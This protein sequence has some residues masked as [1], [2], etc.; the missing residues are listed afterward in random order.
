[1]TESVA[2]EI[3]VRI[4]YE[5]RAAK[6]LLNNQKLAEI[7]AY[8]NQCAEEGSNENQVEESKKAMSQMNAII[9]D[10]TRL[11]TVAEDF[12][13]HYE[14]RIAEG[15]T[16]K[17]KAM[18]VCS[19]RPIAYELYKNIL[20][21][22]P[23]WGKVK[24]AA[25]DVFLSDK[26]KKEIKPMERIKM[27]MTR[28]K[29]DPE[30]LYHLL[31]TKDDRKELDR[32]FKNEK[33][34]FKIAIVV[35]M[36]LTGFDVPFLDTMYIDK[37]IQRHNLIQ[38][39]SRVNRKFEGKQK[40]L[41]VDYIGIKKQMNMAL[42]LYS[43]ADNENIEDIEQSVVVVKDQLDLLSRL[44]Y[45]FDKSGYFTGTPLEQLKTL[46]QASE[47]IQLTQELEK[48]FMYIVKRLKSA[49]DICSGSGIFSEE[50][51]D[52]IHFYLAVRSIIFKLTKGVA[53]DTAE[54]N[55]RVKQMLQDAIESDGIEEIFK[56]GDEG[57][58]EVDIFSDDYM[59]K[60]DKIKLPNTKI[61]LLQKLLAKAIDDVKRINKITG[62]DFSKR[63]QFIV[64]KYNERK[65]DDVL[66]S[67]VLEDFTD[68]II[69]LYYA[70]KKEKES[71]K[72]LGIDFEEKAFYDI[73][74]AL[75]HKYDF[76]YPE[77]KLIVLAQ[78]VKLVVDDKAKYTDWSKRDDIKAELKVDLI[79]LLAESGYPPVDR[80]EIYKEIFEQAE[81]FKK[82]RS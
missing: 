9:G 63:L 46:N 48:R 22:R 25:D 21:L 57:Q 16:V 40:G 51:R 43:N 44:F 76:N 19:N 28:G 20:E 45:K 77:D 35:D 5:G 27:V 39:I 75:A 11:K 67:R 41:V 79:I 37:P 81:N 82:Y 34:N 12:V 70:L 74:K 73:L 3:T 24:V 8:Y 38:T 80:D 66:Q 53:P 42:A 50:Q 29:D 72:D 49:Y 68:E 33:S 62:I 36:W 30:T 31:G 4:V 32:Q 55:N 14:N 26:D 17:G 71:F 6:V 65:E 52:Q 18:F 64:D 2:D 60:I 61:K 1:M 13:K 23:E 69:D 58:T 56:L 59:A 54:M 78:K 7:E 10:P 15:S 47:F